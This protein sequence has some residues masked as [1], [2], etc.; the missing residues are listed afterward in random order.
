MVAKTIQLNFE[1]YWCEP[2]IGGIPAKSGVYGIYACRHNK[3]NTVAIRKL[4]YIGE[5]TN[6]HDRIHSHEKWLFWRHYLQAGE[7]ICLNF[8]PVGVDREQAEAALINH[9]KPP[10]NIEFVGSFPFQQT[11]IYTSGRSTLLSPAFTA[12]PTAGLWACGTNC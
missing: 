11:T 8:A 6:V 4:I 12:H 5:S 1:G 9:H 7:Q 10:E 2:N 3:D